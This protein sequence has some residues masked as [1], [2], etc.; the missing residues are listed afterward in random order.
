MVVGRLLGLGETVKELGQARR[1]AF[2]R[3]ALGVLL[4]LMVAFVWEDSHDWI[5]QQG[6][7]TQ[8]PVV[9]YKYAFVPAADFAEKGGAPYYALGGEHTREYLLDSGGGGPRTADDGLAIR[10]GHPCGE[11]DYIYLFA[12]WLRAEDGGYVVEERGAEEVVGVEEIDVGCIDLCQTCIA[13]RR[14]SGFLL[15]QQVYV[16]IGRAV[17][18]GKLA[19]EGGRGVRGVIVDKKNLQRTVGQLAEGIERGRQKLRTVEIG[20]DYGEERAG[21]FGRASVSRE[22]FLG[23]FST[24]NAP[25]ARPKRGEEDVGHCYCVARI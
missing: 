2:A 23:R 22:Y 21:H 19:A 7:Q 20:D 15:L 11:G 12:V 25:F 10:E 18:F 6:A 8:F 24:E 3:D 13:R 17:L 1:E 4:D 5:G 16:K 9:P 14:G